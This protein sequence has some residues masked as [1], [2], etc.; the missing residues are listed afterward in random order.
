[1]ASELRT[2]SDQ[3][4]QSVVDKIKT[5]MQAGKEL[6]KVKDFQSLRRDRAGQIPN[7]LLVVL[8][9]AVQVQDWG[10]NRGV[11]AQTVVFG[12]TG[13][14]YQPQQVADTIRDVA[15][16][17]ADLFLLDPTLGG[18]V[19]DTRL[20]RLA[21]DDVPPAQEE[22]TQPWATVELVWDYEFLRN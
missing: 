1:M 20:E 14:S 10:A 15:W 13:S 6:D 5:A 2:V 9:R 19:N 22:S 18:L 17:L 16:A 3:V 7:P 11:A 8:T 21:P 4:W 12:V